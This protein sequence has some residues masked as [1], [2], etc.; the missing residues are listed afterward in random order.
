MADPF[1]PSSG[2]IASAI[3]ATQDTEPAHRLVQFG[4]TEFEASAALLP[5]ML[6]DV[7]QH[8][9]QVFGDEQRALRWLR[10]AKPRLHGHTPLQESGTKAGC[11]RVE[12]MLVQMEEGMVV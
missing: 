5:E 2:G 8:A 10:T 1:S 12:E 6:L 9:S 11:R 7:V 3:H 4:L